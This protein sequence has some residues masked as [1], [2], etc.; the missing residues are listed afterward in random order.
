MTN[1]LA[2]LNKLSETLDLN[3]FYTIS[4]S[5]HEIRPQGD[6]NHSLVR[7]LKEQG[8]SVEVQDHGFV[9]C[10]LGNVNIVLT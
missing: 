3:K 5:E 7:K 8:Y 1:Q 9:H 2:Q 10:K 4:F 6:Y